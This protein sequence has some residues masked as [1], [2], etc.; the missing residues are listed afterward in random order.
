M[1]TLLAIA[2]LAVGGAMVGPIMSNV[3]I[4]D[5]KILEKTENIEIR[6]YPPLIVAEVR[7]TGS[8]GFNWCRFSNTSRFYLW[9]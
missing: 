4:P 9:K 7:T 5:Y 8:G 3:E 1:T 6:R 2:V